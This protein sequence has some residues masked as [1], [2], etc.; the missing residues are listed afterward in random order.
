MKE[1]LICYIPTDQNVTDL[2]TKT[3]PSGERRDTLVE[4]LL[5]TITSGLGEEQTPRTGQRGLK[6]SLGLNSLN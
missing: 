2:M 4:R 5:Y 3:L 6:V 1:I